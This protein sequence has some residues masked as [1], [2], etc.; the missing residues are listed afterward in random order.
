MRIFIGPPFRTSMA[1]VGV[2]FTCRHCPLLKVSC[3]LS[4]RPP[5]RCEDLRGSVFPCLCRCHLAAT[6]LH[7]RSHV[8]SRVDRRSLWNRCEGSSSG[9]RILDL[10]LGLHLPQDERVACS[11]PSPV[12]PMYRPPRSPFHPGSSGPVFLLPPFFPICLTL[13]LMPTARTV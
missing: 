5:E 13:V 1:Y 4:R 12:V 3:P 8:G 11:T 2:S 6:V 7:S 9:F 10:V